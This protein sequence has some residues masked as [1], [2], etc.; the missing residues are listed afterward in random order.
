[1]IDLGRIFLSNVIEAKVEIT[2][3]V[4]PASYTE[5]SFFDSESNRTALLRTAS[6]CSKEKQIET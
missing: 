1:M 5:H 6:L 4:M 3:T 2:S